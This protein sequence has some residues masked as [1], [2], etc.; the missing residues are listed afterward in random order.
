MRR[1]HR[2]PVTRETL[3]HIHKVH[4]E[5]LQD[6]QGKS[7]EDSTEMIRQMREERTRQLMGEDEE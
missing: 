2:R 3:E 1:L 6:R 7:F 4:K 5:I